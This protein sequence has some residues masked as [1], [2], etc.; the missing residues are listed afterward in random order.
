MTRT[1]LPE[2]SNSSEATQQGG[3]QPGG[4][5]QD[6]A[7]G[8]PSGTPLDS[9]EIQPGANPDEGGRVSIRD[10]HQGTPEASS[11]THGSPDHTAADPSTGDLRAGDPIAGDPGTG[12]PRTEDSNTEDHHINGPEEQL[13]AGAAPP[14]TPLQ[15]YA[16]GK[17]QREDMREEVA[18]NAALAAGNLLLLAALVALVIGYVF[19]RRTRRAP[20]HPMLQDAVRRAGWS[21]DTP[22]STPRLSTPRQPTSSSYTPGSHGSSGERSPRTTTRLARGASGLPG[23]RRLTDEMEDDEL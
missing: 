15:A 19:T 18:F 12:D 23:A 8:E 1:K 22:M 9:I 17:E 6:V 16:P 4:V 20:T 11:Q 7:L 14:S 13:A 21:G 3:V 2:P 5:Q 10:D